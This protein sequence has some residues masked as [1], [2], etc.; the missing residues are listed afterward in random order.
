MQK[1]TLENKVYPCNEDE[2]VLNCLIRGGALVS[3]S[4]RKGTCK[5]CLLHC[6]SGILADKATDRLNANLKEKGYFYPCVCY[7][8]SDMNISKPNPSDLLTQTI[9]LEKN[10]ISDEEVNIK[11]EPLSDLKHSKKQFINIF[12]DDDNYFYYNLINASDSDSFI[13]IS[14]NK[15]NPN[16]INKYLFEEINIGDYVSVQGPY[17]ILELGDKDPRYTEE[18]HVWPEPD[19]EMW[20]AFDNGLLLNKILEDFYTQVFEDPKLSP[21]FIYTTKDRAIQKQ[22]NFLYRF[23]TGENVYF[24]SFPRNAHHWMVISED[25]FYYRQAMM[26]NILRK[27]GLAEHLI[28]RFRKIEESFKKQIVKDTPWNKLAIGLEF[29][30]E[31]YGSMTMEMDYLCDGCH[32][33]IF[34]GEKVKYHL[35]LGKIFCKNCQKD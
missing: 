33:E 17:N 7:P 31:G 8:I 14:V 22:Y 15:N 5:S 35:H 4:C 9:V 23:F 12:L 18:V 20:E 28:L 25:L 24:G 29:P 21:F 3:F 34:I 10:I 13:E 27:Y 1:I 30:V 2:T 6:D 32:S 16:K 26:E 19:T 11:L